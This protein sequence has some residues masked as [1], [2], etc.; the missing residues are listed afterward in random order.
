MFDRIFYFSHNSLIVAL[1]F[2]FAY[3]LIS[4]IIKLNKEKIEEE[5]C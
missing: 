1:L 3:N 4:Y 2:Q 5:F